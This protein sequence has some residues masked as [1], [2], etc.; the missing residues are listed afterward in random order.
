[1]RKNITRILGQ[2]SIVQNMIDQ[3]HL[4]IVEYFNCWGSMIMRHDVHTK[5]KFRIAITKAAFNNKKTFFT[6]KLD[7][8]LRKKLIKCY[9]WSTALY[10]AET[11]H[12]EK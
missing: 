9:I 6:R 5:L 3:K 1:M 7:L 12:F 11:G 10:G 8:N 4:E 2:P